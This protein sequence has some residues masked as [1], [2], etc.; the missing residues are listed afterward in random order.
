MSATES[1]TR[2]TL[3]YT[4][5]EVDIA[6]IGAGFSGLAAAAALRSR[7]R[8]VVL[9]R[10]GEVGGVWRDNT[11]PGVACDTP[12]HLY[13]LSA[14][15]NPG[16]TRTYSGGGEI[17]AYLRRFADEQ[18]LRPHLRFGQ[19]VQSATWDAD[20]RCWRLRTPDL[21]LR[22][23]VLID[24]AGPLTEPADPHL[25]G[26]ADFAGTAFHSSAW[27]HDHDLRG[28][29]VAVVGTGASAVQFI[30]HIQPLAS[31][32]VVLQRTAPWVVPKP[33]RPTTAGER[34]LLARMPAL[35]RAASWSQWL[36]RDGLHHPVIRR[37]RAARTAGEALSR[38]YLRATI[39]DPALRRRLT[40]RYELG[41]KRILFSNDYY[42]ALSRPNVTVAAAGA[43]ALERGA[44]VGADGSRHEVDTVIFGTGF[45]VASPPIVHRVHGRDGRSLAEVWAGGH[46][47][48]NATQIAGFPNYFRVCGPG[49]GLGTGAMTCQIESQVAYIGR[50]LDTMHRRGIAELDVDPSAQA[51]YMREIGSRLDRT[52]WALGGC[53][54]WYL[55]DGRRP[56]VMWPDTMWRFRRRLARFALED[57]V[58]TS[59][60]EAGPH[61][62]ADLF[63][64]NSRSPR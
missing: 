39:R 16:W 9:E 30:P 43:A 2:P 62:A 50:A 54:S 12:S 27:R 35:A 24:C 22:A 31:H 38:A 29:R 42:Q 60:M 19:D 59:A 34:A 21:V 47:T 28:A 23:R 44:I 48:Y 64:P 53:T 61:P 14:A 46:D 55:D 63:H 32:L 3:E 6:I 1:R 49:T 52:V 5:E 45:D 20:R 8:V 58:V 56:T 25:P 51:R 4:P 36:V 7:G 41:C 33:D 18:H 15:P 57:H 17:G 11:Y 10:A 13:S 37:S 40:P 26:A